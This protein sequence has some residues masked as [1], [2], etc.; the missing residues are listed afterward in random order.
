MAAKRKKTRPRT[1]CRCY[2]GWACENHPNQP[3]GHSGCG[4]SGELCTNPLCDKD[5]DSIFL[6]ARVQPGKRKPPEHQGGQTLPGRL[7]FRTSFPRIEP[8]D[9]KHRGVSRPV[10]GSRSIG[11][12]PDAS[13]YYCENPVSRQVLFQT[14]RTISMPP[15]LSCRCALTSTSCGAVLP[16]PETP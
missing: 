11:I 5:L 2:N 16:A 13:S 9:S 8:C 4:A 6:S 14:F 3:W 1:K 15:P 10:A 7:C 12:T